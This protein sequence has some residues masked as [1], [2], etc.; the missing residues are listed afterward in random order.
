MKKLQNIPVGCLVLGVLLLVFSCW[1][2]T[3]VLGLPTLSMIQ[4]M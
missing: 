1:L 2:A 3:L 4:G